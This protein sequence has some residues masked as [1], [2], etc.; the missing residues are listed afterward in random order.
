[1]TKPQQPE[2]ARS[3]RSEVDPAAVKTRHGGPTDATPPTGP[4]P[5]DNLP[6]HHP[7]QEQDKPAGPPPRPRARRA[8]GTAAA[9]RATA[10]ATKTA[11]RVEGQAT[12]TITDLTTAS[13]AEK[14]AAK[15]SFRFHFE[16]RVGPFAYALGITP[17]TTGVE[18]ADDELRVRFGALN[19]KTPLDNIVGAEITGPY[20]FFKVAG[21]P[22]L[23]LADRGLTL[24]TSTKQGVCVRFRK[25]VGLLRH[26]GL[27]VTVEDADRLVELLT[28]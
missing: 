27:T 2:I 11:D 19:L 5:E 22:H 20:R 16:P 3:G 18:V 17:W 28:A 23:S 9:T 13:A 21:P 14:P 6:G 26:P 15:G 12:A 8:T 1:V 7:D 25:P 4:V 24:A 10:T